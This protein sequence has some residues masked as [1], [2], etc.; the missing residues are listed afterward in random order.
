MRRLPLRRRLLPGRRRPPPSRPRS[1]AMPVGVSAAGAI[2]VAASAVS[3]M[4]AAPAATLNCDCG[5]VTTG[6]RSRVDS[7]WVTSGMFAPP[8][9]VATAE[10]LVAGMLL[11]CNVSSTALS[12]PARGLRDQ[13]F[14]LVAGH[15]D[16]GGEPGKVDVYG[17]GGLGGQLFLGQP[18]VVAQPGQ[19]ADGGRARR[20]GVAGVGDTGDHMIE[21]S[22]VDLVAREVGIAHGLTDGV[23]AGCRVGQ[24]DTGAAS[25]EIAKHHNTIRRQPR[26]GLQRREG[27][28]RVR[29]ECRGHAAGRQARCRC[30][31]PRAVRR[32]S[33][34]P[35]GR[36]PRSRRVYR[37]RRCV[38]SRRGPRRAPALRDAVTRPQPPR[39]PGRRPA[40]RIRSAPCRAG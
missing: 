19:R 27:R 12:T 38:P 36:G 31:T 9:T 13:L 18:A 29:N 28:D 16:I 21:Q 15:S 4:S 35:N 3:A 7:C 34:A 5:V 26:S 23:E 1:G 14:Q 10:T 30:R 25:A 40:R 22:L 17:D 2:P 37:R 39:A 24:R 6:A 32:R 8:P 11:R 20:I 33:L